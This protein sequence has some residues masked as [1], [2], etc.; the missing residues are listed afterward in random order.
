[1]K[2]G[3]LSVVLIAFLLSLAGFVQAEED[4]KKMPS[5]KY[6]GMD[7]TKFAATRMLV[8][9]DDGTAVGT[10]SIHCLAVD[11]AL[12]IDRTPTSIE[13][14][15]MTSKY[16]IDAEKAFW[17]IGGDKQ[18]VMTTQAKWA[19]EQ[20]EYAEKFIRTHGGTLA[21]FDEAMKA[22]YESMYADTKLIRERR[23]AKKMHGTKHQ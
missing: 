14:G 2:R 12:N 4:V 20:K 18:G 15:D 23:K 1:M 22:A 21:T 13:V 8:T 11:L 7:R 9:Y 6:C 19:F 5:C 10:C 17:V 16:L 3:I